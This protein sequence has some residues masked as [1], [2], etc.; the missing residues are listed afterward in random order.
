MTRHLRLEAVENFR[1]FGDY[2]TAAGRRLKPGRLYRSASHGRATDADL[3]AID[4]LG[5]AVVVD[6]RRPGERE[7]D[8]ARRPAGFS[9]QVIVNDEGESAGEDPWWAFVRS[10]D[11]S[12][13]AFRG[14]LLNYY[15]AAP[16]APRHIDLFSRYFRALAG[17]DGPV[18]IHCAA[19]K[20]RTGVL[21]ALTHHLVGVHEDDILADYLL[22]NDAERIAARA[23]TVARMIQE[24]T[25]R[26]A[27]DAAIRA[28]IGV[29]AEYLAQ[30][31]G[32]IE[33]GHGS[34][35][36]YLREAIGVDAALAEALE[37]RLLD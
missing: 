35:D 11:L 9:G 2:A 19:G 24:A 33:A 17:A 7:R 10:C 28:A 30:A 32:A 8:P 27:T 31:L 12:A 18:L 29:E 15:R 1:D 3:D 26:T 4:R 36:A 34:V 21:A 5:L 37:A 13:A 16:Y 25:G 22:T 23:P 6:L 14:Y 20:D